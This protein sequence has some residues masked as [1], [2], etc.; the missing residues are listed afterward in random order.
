M[1]DECAIFDP[2]P[3]VA[4]LLTADIAAAFV[5]YILGYVV[6]SC[7]GRPFR[8][9][10]VYALDISKIA[11]V[12]AG[13]VALS[14]LL[15][16][17][18]FVPPGRAGTFDPLSWFFATSLVR[19]CFCVVVALLIGGL[20]TS[21]LFS[22]LGN[23]CGLIKATGALHSFGRYAPDEAESEKLLGAS[24]SGPRAT[25]WL[26]QFLLWAACTAGA[27]ALGAFCLPK[28]IALAPADSS[29]DYLL[30]RAIFGVA[31]PCATKQLAVSGG[32]RIV[33]ELLLLALVDI[34]NRYG[35]VGGGRRAGAGDAGGAESAPV[36]STGS[37]V[38]ALWEYSAQYEDE[39]SF[40]AGELITIEGGVVGEELWFKGRIGSRTGL[41]PSNYVGEEGSA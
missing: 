39:L 26:A 1:P 34:C 2:L 37:R 15:A 5:L 28:L 21:G 33:L 10:L 7:F 22:T 16:R 25:W 20:L 23:R 18:A 3:S 6:R 32:L 31:K 38:R 35:G 13:G 29:P 19:E 11:L 9:G 8:S 12:H 40:K 17:G 30:A 36:L 24:S 41:I 14:A 27:R 4:L